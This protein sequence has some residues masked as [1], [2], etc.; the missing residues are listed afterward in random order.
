MGREG[1]NPLVLTVD[2]EA[3]PVGADETSCFHAAARNAASLYAHLIQGGC[4]SA[5]LDEVI[6]LQRPV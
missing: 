4:N 5:P 6:N 1:L 3:I 2:G